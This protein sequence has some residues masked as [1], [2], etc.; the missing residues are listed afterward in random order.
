MN[1]NIRNTIRNKS[2]DSRK[3][4]IAT[5]GKNHGVTKEDILKDIVSQDMRENSHFECK[6]VK[7]LSDEEK[8]NHICKP[9]VGFLNSLD[10]HGLLI[11]GLDMRNDNPIHKKP[12]SNEIIKNEEQLRSIIHS[13]ISTIPSFSDTYYLEIFKVPEDD[14]CNYFLIE[15]TR[16]VDNCIYYSTHSQLGYI[17]NND[18]TIT[19]KLPELINLLAQKNNPRLFININKTSNDVKKAVFSLYLLNEGF[20]PGR[21]VLIHLECVFSN[22]VVFDIS[23]KELKRTSVDQLP[24][25]KTYRFTCGMPPNTLLIYPGFSIILGELTISGIDGAFGFIN[26]DIF[27]DK[28][29]TTQHIRFMCYKDKIQFDVPHREYTPYLVM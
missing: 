20:Q 9:L 8:E 13:W 24:N 18:E 15:I 5:F 1:I 4:I 14:N 12:I 27:E 10:G 2:L 21:N 11:L 7:K 26:V 16:K 3:N 25:R 23:G 22:G 6:Q 17:R 19:L 29:R 28:G